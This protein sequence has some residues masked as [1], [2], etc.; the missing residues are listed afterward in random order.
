MPRAAPARVFRSKDIVITEPELRGAT[1]QVAEIV[2]RLWAMGSL[3]PGRNDEQV[4]DQAGLFIKTRQ[5]T[6]IG[7]V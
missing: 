5:A 7:S 4:A 2:F 1:A 3:Q 6:G